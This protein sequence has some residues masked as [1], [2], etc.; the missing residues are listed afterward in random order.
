MDVHSTTG[1][2]TK[3]IKRSDKKTSRAA[4]VDSRCSQIHE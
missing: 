2:A 1:K 3:T 4:Y